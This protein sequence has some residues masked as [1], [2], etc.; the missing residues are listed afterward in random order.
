[1]IEV[2]TQRICSNRFVWAALAGTL[3][4]LADQP[5][6]AGYNPL[7]EMFWDPGIWRTPAHDRIVLFLS[8][9][10]TTLFCH[11]VLFVFQKV[12]HQGTKS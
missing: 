1:M 4:W 9:L 11:F 12:R 10:V 5:T 6:V 2:R 3:V 7:L 8:W